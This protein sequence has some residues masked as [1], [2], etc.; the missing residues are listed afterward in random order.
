MPDSDPLQSGVPPIPQ[1]RR[2]IRRFSTFTIALTCIFVA[3]GGCCFVTSLLFRVEVVN[4]A[5]GVNEGAARI[6]DWTLPPHF[7]GKSS[8]TIDNFLMKFDLVKF[9]HEQGRGLIVVGQLKW[10]TIQLS[11]QRAQIQDFIEQFAPEMKKINIASSESQTLT[12]R[13]LPAKFQF[14]TG[15]D[16]ASTT[17][18]LEVTGIFRGKADDA[19]L[20][21]QCEEGVLSSTEINDF[22]KSI[23]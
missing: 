6:T 3:F 2:P 20:I 1:T 17:Q 16:R 9:G 22:L 12:V 11:D 21:L 13:G 10:K 15:E 23:H 18:Y 8:L 7:A 19:I 4:T 14:G 5:A